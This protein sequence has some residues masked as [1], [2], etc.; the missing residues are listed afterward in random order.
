MYRTKCQRRRS[1]AQGQGRRSSRTCGE[2]RASERALS[3]AYYRILSRCPSN[4]RDEERMTALFSAPP[5]MAA[6]EGWRF[7]NPLSGL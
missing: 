5:E 4:G 1:R 2:A 7:A 6:N 3:R